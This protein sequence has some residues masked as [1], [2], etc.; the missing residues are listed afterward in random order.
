MEGFTVTLSDPSAPL[1]FP[2][3]EATIAPDDAITDLIATTAGLALSTTPE[4]YPGPVA[5]LEKQWIG[6][7]AGNVNA[8]V[9]GPNWFI[10]TGAGNDAIAAASGT[11][12]LDGGAGSNVF[13]GG[14]GR[15]T[16]FLD[17]RTFAA[18]DL[19]APVWSTITNLGPGDAVTLWGISQNEFALAFIDGLGAPGFT[20]LTLHATRIGEPLPIVSLTLT[21]FAIADH[22]R[23]LTQSF[24]F[25]PSSGSH[26]LHI[27]HA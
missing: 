25:D 27:A 22:G 16:F 21:G 2:M 5:G 12:V 3:A 23:T 14:T 20:G 8:T 19:S 6:N 11:N 18:P 17:A 4:F 24:G 9:A 15:D 10:R 13:T 7:A 1:Y 26:Y